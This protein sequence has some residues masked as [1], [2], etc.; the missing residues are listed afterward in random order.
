MEI[1]MTSFTTDV[2]G[3]TR[4]AR[5][6][7]KLNDLRIGQRLWIGFGVVILL[8]LTLT[9]IGVYR[10]GQINGNIRQM[11]GDYYPQTVR[12]N[13]IKGELETI[14]RSMRNLLFMTTVD[15]IQGELGSVAKANDNIATQLNNFEHALDTEQERALLL[16]VTAARKKYV[17]VLGRFISTVKDGQVE[18]A[19]DLILPEIAPF[20]AAYFKALD[21][22]VAFQ[23]DRMDQAGRNAEQ[24]SSATRLLM[25]AMAAVAALLAVAVAFLVSRSI[26]RPLR[27]AIDIAE[28][29]AGGDLQT[30]VQVSS[31]DETGQ[32][33]HALKEMSDS[34]VKAVGEV[35]NGTDTISVAAEEISLGNADL[36]QRTEAQASELEKTASAMQQLTQTV[37]QNAESARQANRLVIDASGVA[38]KGGAAVSEVVDMMRSI[39][40]SSRKIADIIGVIDGIAFQT[41]ILALNAAVEAARAGEQGRGFAVVAS[42]VRSLAQRSASAA[43]E[44]KLLIGDSVKQVDAGGQLVDEAG[45]TMDALVISVRHVADIMLEI[46]GAS[47]EQSGDIVRINRAISE[48]DQ[49]TQQNAALVEEAAAAAQSMQFQTHALNQAVSVFK[50]TSGAG[51][52][53]IPTLYQT[54]QRL[55]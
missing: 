51:Q 29:V 55:N 31:Q 36:S 49:M 46:S 53:V 35:R 25:I 28:R 19:R 48:I 40:E 17:P 7:G 39:K 37:S 52:L 43:K 10:I 16:Q 26:T 2:P 13:A 24:V 44:I 5:R 22:L 3:S 8:M 47:D 27:A 33:L 54:A 12:A 21:S 50:L 14:A 1:Q 38:T 41:N 20:Q 30:E 15:E 9:T 6:P 4:R 42:E 23:S 18:Q 34:L 11:S 32:L 45:K